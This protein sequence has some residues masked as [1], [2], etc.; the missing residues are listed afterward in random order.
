MRQTGEFQ[1][2]KLFS[3]TDQ[4]TWW[5]KSTWNKWASVLERSSSKLRKIS[6]KKRWTSQFTS[7]WAT[8]LNRKQFMTASCAIIDSIWFTFIILYF[9]FT[10]RKINSQ[11]IY[12]F[13]RRICFKIINCKS[14]TN[15]NFKLKMMKYILASLLFSLCASV[16]PPS[17]YNYR[18]VAC[19]YFDFAYCASD[20]TCYESTT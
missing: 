18:C 16:D 19:N 20:L 9:K 2:A 14:Q 6:L 15:L 4:G 11:F 1:K 3:F 12:W 17:T 7:M 13:F 8:E 10:L 5:K